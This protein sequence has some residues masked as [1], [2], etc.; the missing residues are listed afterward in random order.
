[1]NEWFYV[2]FFLYAV[3]IPGCMI[4]SA[5]ADGRDKVGWGD[6]L[7]GMFWFVIDAFIVLYVFAEKVWDIF[8][9]GKK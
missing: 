7:Y 6:V 8:R 5:S 2:A 9:V 1:M 4:D 3:R